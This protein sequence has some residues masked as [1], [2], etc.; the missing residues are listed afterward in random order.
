MAGFMEKLATLNSA[1]RTL[2]ALVV[3][4]GIGVGGWYGYQEYHAADLALKEK[5]EELAL[6]EKRIVALQTDLDLANQRLAKLELALRLLKVDHRLAYVDVID[7]GMAGGEPFTEVVFQEV[8]DQNKPLDDPRMFRIKGSEVHV[9]GWIVNFEDRYIEGGDPE[10]GNPLFLFKRLHGDSQKP[11]DAHPLDRDGDLPAAYRRGGPPS[12]LEREIWD[13]FWEISRDEK[14][15]K[16]R[17][18]RAMGGTS[19]YWP[20]EKGK[21]YRLEM[22]AGGG[23]TKQEVGP[24]PPPGQPAA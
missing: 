9:A 19:V 24:V 8:D 13:R 20:A 22:R 11:I 16:A 15:T 7:Q 18:I 4:G 6:R 23:L 21:R 1:V 12:E 10:R 17:G 14:Q 2:L 5:D 3:V